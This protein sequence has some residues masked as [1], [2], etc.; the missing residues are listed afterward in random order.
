MSNYWLMNKCLSNQ[1][2]GVTAHNHWMENLLCIMTL[3][4][5][6]TLAQWQEQLVRIIHLKQ[7]SSAQWSSTVNTT[8]RNNLAMEPTPM[9]MRT[10]IIKPLEWFRNG[11]HCTSLGHHMGGLWFRNSTRITRSHSI[12][13]DFQSWHH[14]LQWY[15]KAPDWEQFIEAMKKE[16]LDHKTKNH[17]E[18]VP[19]LKV[20][21]RTAILP[22]VWSMKRKWRILTNE[23]YNGKLD[24]MCMVASK[25][26]MFTIGKP[27]PQLLDGHPSD[28][29]WSLQQSMDRK[30]SKSTLFWCFHKPTLKPS[31]GSTA[32]WEQSSL[33]PLA[34]LEQC[35]LVSHIQTSIKCK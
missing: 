31:W 2:S 10:R 23:I 1:T 27:S 3:N 14:V 8:P 6:T 21:N 30:W 13:H 22:A 11:L 9:Q 24:S 32:S 19:W 20:P 25:S 15:I 5:L 17:W 18:L 12:C 33:A 29:S 16:V 7:P 35:N 34:S 4:A 26:R 28:C